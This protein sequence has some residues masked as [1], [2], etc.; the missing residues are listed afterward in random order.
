M[1][2]LVQEGKGSTS[3]HTR[4]GGILDDRL[5]SYIHG[6]GWAKGGLSDPFCSFFAMH[7]GESSRIDTRRDSRQACHA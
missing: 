6:S 5:S 1:R 3:G 7:K 4:N 2:A